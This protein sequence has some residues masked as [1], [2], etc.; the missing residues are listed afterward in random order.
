MESNDGCGGEGL[1]EIAKRALPP[2]FN[3]VWPDLSWEV[4]SVDELDDEEGDGP[5]RGAN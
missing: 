4:V 1:P 3:E 2:I 5:K